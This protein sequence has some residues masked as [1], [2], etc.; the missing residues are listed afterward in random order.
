ML[1]PA[2][3][4]RYRSAMLPPSP[5]TLSVWRTVVVA[6]P[7]SL[8]VAVASVRSHNLENRTPPT[9]M[10]STTFRLF[11]RRQFH[12]CSVPKQSLT[13]GFSSVLFY[14]TKS[15]PPTSKMSLP[16]VFF[17]M[18]ADGEQLGR[19]IIEVNAPTR[20]VFF[21][22]RLFTMAVRAVHV[23]THMSPRWFQGFLTRQTVQFFA[24]FI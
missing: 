11:A 6:F 16:K 8:D 15:K 5:S 13:G 9:T 3:S 4:G 1:P 24:F 7:F 17:D 21:P 12:C 19:I 18:T 22:T 20:N 23:H 10:A 14:S 2:S